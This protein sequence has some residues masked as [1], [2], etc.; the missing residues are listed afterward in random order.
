[1]QSSKTLVESNYFYHCDGEVEMISNKSCDNIYRGKTFEACDGILTIRHGNRCKVKS[2]LFLGRNH[3]RA[4]GV[5]ITGEDHRVRN[6]EFDALLGKGAWAAISMMQGIPNSPLNGYFQL[7]RALISG[8]AVRGC[9]E[10]LA[11]SVAGKD[12]SLPTV[13]V[14]LAD[15]QFSNRSELK[16]HPL[17]ARQT[18]PEW[19]KR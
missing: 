1:M 8:N 14:T 3:Q 11:E 15:N 19:M 18:G 4:G 7:K 5:R 9:A 16:L 13:E 6:N 12:T 17:G 10:I 2:N